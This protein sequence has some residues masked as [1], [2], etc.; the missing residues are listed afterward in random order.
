MT[1]D[2]DRHT[3]VVDPS[4]NDAMTDVTSEIDDFILELDVAVEAHMDWTR[5]VLRCAVLHVSPGE[6]VLAPASHTLCR[7]GRWFAANR[8]QFA[9]LD[10]QGTLRLETTHQTMHKAIRAICANILAGLPGQSHELETFER[11]QAE[12][13]HLLAEFKTR[14]LADIARH[15]PLT[16]LPLR[17]G[18]EAEFDQ[19]RKNCQRNHTLLYVVMIDVDRFKYIND[20]YG[21]PVGDAV[22]RALANT[23]KHIVRPSDA[24]HRFGGEEFL[25]LMQCESPEGAAAAAHRLVNAVRALT[26]PTAQGTTLTLTVTLGLAHV[27]D[28]ETLASAIDRA[29]RALY[30][31]K[32]AGRDRY[33]MAA[34]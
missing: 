19:A 27:P 2:G 33:V 9:R 28:E 18:I 10:E 29:D 17:H 14:L 26:V 4:G 8:E 13:I 1:A 34:G 7:F 22:L 12:L 25:L 20:R 30:E 15:D 6:D 23:L 32:K 31:G 16:G 24:L 3:P 11:T 21:H 5:R